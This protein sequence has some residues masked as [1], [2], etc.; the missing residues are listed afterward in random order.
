MKTAKILALMTVCT[1]L[2]GLLAGCAEI[3]DGYYSDGTEA[4]T[5]VSEATTSATTTTEATTT[6]PV[7]TT[8][9]VTTTETTTVPEETEPEESSTDVEDVIEPISTEPSWDYSTLSTESNGYGQGVHLD[10]LNRPRGALNF[11][12]SYSQ[13]SAEAIQDTEEKVIMLTFDQGYEN[14]YTASILDTLAEKG[15]KA[16]F[17]ITYDYVSRNPELVQR[18]I[19]EGH[20]VGSHSWHHYSMPELSVEEMTEE[21]MYLHDYMIEN[22]GLQMTL[23]RPP[24]GEYSELS[25]AVTGDLGYTTVLWSFAYADWDTDNQ[26]DPEESLQ[27]LIDRVHPGAIYLLHS[28]SETNTE[29]L[30]EFIDAVMA[31]GY[32]FVA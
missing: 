30:G 28:V 22:F 11:N 7:T 5:S 8:E 10:D 21:I 19:D 29:I 23:F 24:K 2:L 27:K 9:E 17:F 26:P 15:V 31:E 20:T 3:S 4:T 18:M 13:Y 1:L 32:E 12:E 25:L 14:G 16:T 6:E